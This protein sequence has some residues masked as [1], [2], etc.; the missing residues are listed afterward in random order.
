[1]DIDWNS[2]TGFML[3]RV[4]RKGCVKLWTTTI[5]TMVNEEGEEMKIKEKRE[6]KKQK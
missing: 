5:V 2:V 3:E 6:R 1:M 4:D